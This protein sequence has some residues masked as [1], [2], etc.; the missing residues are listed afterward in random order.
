MMYT[1]YDLIGAGLLGVGIGI[2]VVLF[3]E[4]KR[5]S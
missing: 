3:A 4:T 2:M 1:I 5:G